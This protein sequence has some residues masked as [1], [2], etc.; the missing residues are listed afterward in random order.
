MTIQSCRPLFELARTIGV[1][2]SDTEEPMTMFLSSNVW[3]S[4]SSLGG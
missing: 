1:L 3:N 2:E 4:N